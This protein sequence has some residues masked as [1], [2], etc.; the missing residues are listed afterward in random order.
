[1]KKPRLNERTIARL[2]IYGLAWCSKYYYEIK[3]YMDSEGNRY[4]TLE[5]TNLKTGDIDEFDWDEYIKKA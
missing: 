4:E 5:R 1:M 3:D 2:E